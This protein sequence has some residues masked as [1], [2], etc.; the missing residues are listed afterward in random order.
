MGRLSC[1]PSQPVFLPHCRWAGLMRGAVSVAL[2]YYYFDPHGT[3][4]D[5]HTSTMITTTLI[6][7]L[8]SIMAFGA[9][10]KPLLE[11]VMG[12]ASGECRG[13][14]VGPGRGAQARQ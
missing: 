9:A 10:T 2:V 14:R 11:Q 5:R 8:I 1:R 3:T 12:P 7:V 4:A 13:E 6:V